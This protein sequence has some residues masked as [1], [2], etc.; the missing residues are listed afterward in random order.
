[1]SPFYVETPK[2]N[3]LS[4]SAFNFIELRRKILVPYVEIFYKE[5]LYVVFFHFAHN[6]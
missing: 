1:L 3:A 2:E 5:R 4:T 6:G